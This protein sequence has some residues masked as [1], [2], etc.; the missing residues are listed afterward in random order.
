MKD[1]NP[2]AFG[3]A[4]LGGY[5]AAIL[6]LL[7]SHAAPGPAGEPPLIRLAAV[8]EPDHTLHAP[9]IARL[10]AAGV[11]VVQRYEDLLALPI[12]ALWLPLP[13]DLHRPF[14]VQALAAGKAVMCEKP[15]AGSLQD[16]DAMI[17]ARDAARRPALIGYQDVYDPTTLPLK[18]RLVDGLIGPIRRASVWACWPR[19]QA[20]F[21][22]NP[23][24]GRM[25]RGDA[26]VM[27][28]PAN[29]ALAHYLNI[30]LFL[31]GATPE[32]SAVPVAVEAE[33]YRT[34]D[35]ENH[36][37]MSMR[38]TL[39]GGAT[40]LVNFTHAC[41]GLIHP[42]VDLHGDRG[43]VRRSNER[44]EIEVGG[45]K[46][47]IERPGTAA[48]WAVR[49]IARLTRGLDAPEVAAATLEVARAQTL[50][51]NGASA[52]ALITPIAPEHF[53]VVDSLGSPL[54]AI[55]GI[56]SAF[57]ESVRLHKM[58]HEAGL[59]PWTTPAGKLDLTT[60]KTFAGPRHA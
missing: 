20:Y 18:R 1:S 48:S 54:R 53:R 43:H 8:T 52:A 46:E 44:I 41:E 5:A 59:M 9:L 21:G 28:A 45:Q 12:E 11:T 34:Y 25:R 2:V 37:T 35:I 51:V 49:K 30:A 42:V 40:L 47:V 24:A 38:L 32:A 31:L 39:A 10:R 16:V 6:S 50:A 3:L 22:R 33:L 7:E 56:E 15:A 19:S 17:A 58:L 55:N 36:D 60:Y 13:I 26:W 23:W 29:N 27:D 14:T 4:G 57:A